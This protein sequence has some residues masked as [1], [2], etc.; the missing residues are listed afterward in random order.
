MFNGD[1]TSGQG[2]DATKWQVWLNDWQQMTTTSD[3]RMIPI[4]PVHGNHENGDKGNLHYIFNS[5]YHENDSSSI[6]YSA[7]IG[8]D[9]LHLMALNSEI[10]TGGAQK[11]WIEKRF[12]ERHQLHF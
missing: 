7:S 8:G 11:K 12:E 10:E 9:Q 3:G 4:F 5:P 1:F 6:Y 2:I